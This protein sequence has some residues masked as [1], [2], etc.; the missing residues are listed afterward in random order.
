MAVL[1]IS[2]V[3]KERDKRGSSKEFN[4]GFPK[5]AIQFM[6]A[7]LKT[8]KISTIEFHDPCALVQTAIVLVVTRLDLIAHDIKSSME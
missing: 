7:R 6:I 2:N 4:E 3:F 8:P 5:E 1:Q